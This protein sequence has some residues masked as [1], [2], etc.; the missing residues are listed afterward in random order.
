MRA[1]FIFL[2]SILFW[3]CAPTIKETKSVFRFNIDAGLTSLDPAFCRNQNN[4]WA[5]NMLYNGLVQISDDMQ[6]QPAIAKSWIISPSG[7]EYTFSLRNDVFFHD[8]EVFP[9]HKGRKLTAS[10]VVYSFNRLIDKNVASSGAWIFN[11]KMDSVSAFSAL[12]DSTFVLKLSK[13]FPPLISMLTV[14][15]CSIVPNEAVS[16]YG[17]DFRSHPVGTG[18]FKFNYWYEGEALALLKNEKYFEKDKNGQ[19]LPKLDAVLIRFIPDKQTAFM[20]FQKGNLDFFNGIDG[21]FKDDLLTKNGE[22]QSKYKGQFQLLNS[23]FMNTEYMGFAIDD[24]LPINAGSPILNVKYRQAINYAIDKTKLVKYL[25][26]SVGIPGHAGFIP[27]GMPSYDTTMV[28]GY[29]YNPA[30]TKALLSELGY[31]KV[32]PPT[33]TLTTTTTYRN[34]IEFVQGELQKAGI[35]S[36][37]EVTRA[38]SLRELIGK[39]KVN[40]FRG[41]WTA[42]YPDAENYLS[43]FYSKNFAPAGPNYT[44]YYSE[45]FDALW[46]KAYNITSDAERYKMYQKMDNL[47]MKTCP[48]IILYYDRSLRMYQNNVKGLTSNPLNLLQLKNVTVQ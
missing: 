3:G 11:D 4:V 45:E 14:Q 43:V 25:Q 16:F 44:H 2:L 34:L 27:V 40:F 6:V 42:D 48:V 33:V 29:S 1:F 15:Y 20:E 41:S 13:P 37:V 24:T 47:V 10:D 36:K 22:L 17:K 39:G 23:P 35:P 8:S 7:L 9:K 31:D 30:K 12:N 5:V 28:H 38:A 32:P 19:A 26:N 18:P 21:N 46:Q